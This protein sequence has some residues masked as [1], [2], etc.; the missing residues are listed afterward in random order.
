[1]G[2]PPPDEAEVLRK[3]A[4]RGKGL[5]RADALAAHRDGIGGAG[6]R[7]ED[8]GLAG[9]VL[10]DEKGDGSSERQLVERG[11]DV[12]GEGELGSVLSGPIVDCEGLEK[13]HGG[14]ILSA[15]LSYPSRLCA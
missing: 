11:K 10:P 1:M 6:E 4:K 7:L 14:Q 12:E 9:A 3:L 5:V 13:D 2:A 15:V 8:G